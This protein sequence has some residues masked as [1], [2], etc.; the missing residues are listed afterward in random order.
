MGCRLTTLVTLPLLWSSYS[1]GSALP[2]GLATPV[3]P[4]HTRG[5]HMMN[6]GCSCGCYGP[7][8]W[9][10]QPIFIQNGVIQPGPAA[11]GLHVIRC[12]RACSLEDD[13]FCRMICRLCSILSSAPGA[14]SK[15]L[16]VACWDCN[17]VIGDFALVMLIIS[18]MIGRGGSSRSTHY[19]ILPV[20]LR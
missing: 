9:P 8:P 2:Q 5:L 13:C 17:P 15:R 1:D 19:R 20:R 16:I 7:T 4:T 3:N 14:A 11:G 6:A 18:M 12:W 10:L